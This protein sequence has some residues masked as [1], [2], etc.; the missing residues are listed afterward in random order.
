MSYLANT[1][2]RKKISFKKGK[3]SYLYSSSGKKYLDFVQGIAVNSLGHANNHLIKTINKQSKK[4]W[5]VSN[6]FIIPEQE[7]LAKRLVQKTFAEAVIFQN[8]GA[9]ATEAAIKAA[10]RYFYSIGKKKK[11]RIL[12]VNNSF[13]GRTLATIFASN[14][15]KMTEG[16]SPKVD[17]F[18]HFNFGQHKELEKKITSKTAAIMVET[19][20][21]E[22]GI[23]VIPDFCLKGLRKLCNKKKILLILDEVQ[24]GVGRTGKF[25]AYEH[26]KIN[27]DIVP[28]A[29]GIGGGFPIGALLMSKKVAKAMTPGTHGSTFGGNPLAMSVGNKVLDIV[30]KR[31]FLKSVQNI[32]KYFH[33][34]LHKLQSDFPHVI[35]EVRGIGLLIGLQLF[36]DQTKFIKKLMESQ[37]LTIRAAE[38]VVRILPPL[39]VK[40]QEIDL[41]VTILRKVCRNYK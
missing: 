25:F 6:A 26:A 8:S 33:S 13:H 27:P 31:G 10:R 12:C 9:E 24:C 7:K 22:G 21:G 18:D 29:K 1:Y 20:M 17:G 36:E 38:N 30:F 39:T 37:M 28:I 16:F 41:A 34:E 35:K 5:H 4:L 23:K 15:K 3:G 32:S 14:N 40:K 19:I 11:N 2:N